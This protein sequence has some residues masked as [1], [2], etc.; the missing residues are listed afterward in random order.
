MSRHNATA[1]SVPGAITSGIVDAGI[2]HLLI[3]IACAPRVRYA[4]THIH[5]TVARLRDHGQWA[6][7]AMSR[8]AVR[9]ATERLP[10]PTERLS[11]SVRGQVCTPLNVVGEIRR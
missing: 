6:G 11:A 5:G 2:G 8:T 10:G 7:A 4:T 9:P 1:R 3:P